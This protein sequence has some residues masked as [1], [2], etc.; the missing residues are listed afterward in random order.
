MASGSSC[1]NSASVSLFAVSSLSDTASDTISVACS[2]SATVSIFDSDEAD[3]SSL[4][5]TA[6]AVLVF[7]SSELSV[8]SAD[9]AD[10]VE[11]DLLPKDDAKPVG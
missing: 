11:S 7:E 10:S 8:A 6:L 2:T 5:S 9:G 3:E 1:A 4:S